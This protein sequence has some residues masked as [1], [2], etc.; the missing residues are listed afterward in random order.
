MVAFYVRKIQTRQNN[1]K[2]HSTWVLDDVPARW[3]NDVAEALENS[4]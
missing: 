4:K 2:T 3:R 1:P